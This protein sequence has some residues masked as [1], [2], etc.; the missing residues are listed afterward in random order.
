[1]EQWPTYQWSVFN[2]DRSQQWVVRTDIFEDFIQAV[3]KVRSLLPNYLGGDA[4]REP[5]T[6]GSLQESD[7]QESDTG[8]PEVRNGSSRAQAE[9]VPES[10]AD[11]CPIHR[12]LMKLRTGKNNQTWYDHRWQ[13]HGVWYQCNGKSQRSNGGESK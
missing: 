1:M 10:P 12:C 5:E 2:A 8:E 6:E 7:V 9:I 13:E 3:S 11:F 4:A